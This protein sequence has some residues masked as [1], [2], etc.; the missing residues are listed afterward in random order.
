MLAIEESGTT[1]DTSRVQTELFTEYHALPQ[2]DLIL[3][4]LNQDYKNNYPKEYEENGFIIKALNPMAIDKEAELLQVQ[5]SMN[6]LEL[7]NKL[8]ELGYDST[9]AANYAM[10]KIELSELGVPNNKPTPEMT[11]DTPVEKK[12]E[13]LLKSDDGDISQLGT[14]EDKIDSDKDFDIDAKFTSIKPLMDGSLSLIF[15][16]KPVTQEKAN[17]I[18]YHYRSDGKVSYKSLEES[19]KPV[20]GKKVED[21]EVE[22]VEEE[23]IDCEKLN[24]LELRKNYNPNRDSSTGRFDFGKGNSST[25]GGEYYKATKIET[26]DNDTMNAKLDKALKENDVKLKKDQKLSDYRLAVY[27]KVFEELPDSGLSIKF[28][29]NNPDKFLKSKEYRELSQKRQKRYNELI[30]KI[31]NSIGIKSNIGDVYMTEKDYNSLINDNEE[32]SKFAYN[33]YEDRGFSYDDRSVKLE[34]IGNLAGQKPKYWYDSKEEKSYYDDLRENNKLVKVDDKI[35]SIIEKRAKNSKVYDLQYPQIT[36]TEE[37]ALKEYNLVSAVNQSLRKGETTN[38][39]DYI[40]SAI[41]KTYTGEQTLYRG[42]RGDFA[43]KVAN[44][45]PGDT[46]TDKGFMSTSDI[47]GKNTNEGAMKFG[48]GGIIMEI[49]SNSGFGK[50]IDM[51]PYVSDLSFMSENEILLNRNTTLNF[52]YY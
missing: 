51:M 45:K 15:K 46:V 10:D 9:T 12:K 24:F 38:A 2:I 34:I 50:K 32:F 44:L 30:Q 25:G 6:S 23:E 33:F 14:P 7:Y 27:S 43:N 41:N 22:D 37:R 19:I 4:A 8:I 5:L 1:R 28:D 20:D 52:V 35:K 17:E 29:S 21:K 42:I 49:K 16:T 11:E 18:L 39:A 47:I 36:R 3:D 48:K 26:F 31:G 40:Q 13:G